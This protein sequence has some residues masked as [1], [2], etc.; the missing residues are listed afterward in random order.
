MSQDYKYRLKI[1]DTC[2]GC[3]YQIYDCQKHGPVTEIPRNCGL[4]SCLTEFG[5]PRC[6]DLKECNP[7]VNVTDVL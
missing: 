3:H 4:P 2:T 1:L 6:P 7:N 5:N